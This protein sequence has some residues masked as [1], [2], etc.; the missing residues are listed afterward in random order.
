MHASVIRCICRNTS[1]LCCPVLCT[2]T[3]PALAATPALWNV[4]ESDYHE[5]VYKEGIQKKLTPLI[6]GTEVAGSTTGNIPSGCGLHDSSAALIP[7]VTA[8]S[9]PFVLLSTGTWSISLNPFNHSILTAEELDQDCLSYL[10]YQG[11][12]V[13]ASR[14]FAG[15]EHE[16]Q[17]KRIAA[18]FHTAADH[19]KSVQYDASLCH[20]LHR[21]EP[22]ETVKGNSA[23]VS[24][25]AFSRRNLHDFETCEEAYHQ[26]IMD[27]IKQQVPSTKRVMNGSP[28]SKIFVD[29]GFSKNDVYMHLLAAAFPHIGMYSATV[30]QASALGAAIAIRKAWNK[31]ALPANLVKVKRYEPTY[32]IV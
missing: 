16:Q 24:Q 3:S 19:Y 30:A 15:Y 23:M 27:I 13:K 21:A 2:A 7:Y 31:A 4:T 22:E 12:A 14:L 5:W 10:S 11:N 9:E 17:V 20:K 32:D 29:G 26:L 25:S 1:A 6:S 28:V 18:H 8:F